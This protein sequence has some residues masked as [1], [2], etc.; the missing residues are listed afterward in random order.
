MGFVA[1]APPYQVSPC[2]PGYIWDGTYCMQPFVFN[3]GP[4]PP[5]LIPPTNGLPPIGDPG[6]GG[7]GTLGI[8]RCPP[9]Y[10]CS[11]ASACVDIGGL[12]VCGCIGA[13]KGP[14][15]VIPGDP[16]TEVGPGGD[17]KIR[18]DGNGRVDGKLCCGSGYH[19][20]KAEYFLK[21]GTRIPEGS[22]CVRNR[23][24]NPLNPRALDRAGS[25]VLSAK[26]AASWLAKVTIPK[27]RRG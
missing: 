14:G 1:A 21:N 13:C 12:E 2:P 8:N 18:P 10:A 9:G 26:R 20:N 7:F 17:P 5:G 4:P 11:G 25:R 16:I 3:H 27:K 6:N 22:K 19:P 15:G 24:R 23:R